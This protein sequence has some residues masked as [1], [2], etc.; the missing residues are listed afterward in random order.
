MADVE[1]DRSLQIF[2]YQPQISS[3]L[4]Q[5]GE[6]EARGAL[7]NNIAHLYS[8]SLRVRT[9][10]KYSLHIIIFLALSILINKADASIVSL[11]IS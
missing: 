7:K 9:L 3:M 5:W 10:H 4:T 6:R 2:S 11:N 1:E 8:T